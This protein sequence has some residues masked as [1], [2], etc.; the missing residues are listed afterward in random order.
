MKPMGTFL[1]IFLMD[2]SIIIVPDPL[3]DAFLR[4]KVF[5]SLVFASSIT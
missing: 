3:F 2:A 5:K 1:F 4:G